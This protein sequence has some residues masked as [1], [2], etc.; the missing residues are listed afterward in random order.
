MDGRVD[1]HE[2]LAP[3]YRDAPG[4]AQIVY[5]QLPEM[6]L[7]D[8]DDA[9]LEPAQPRNNARVRHLEADGELE[10]AG[11][12]AY[13]GEV[14][15]HG[16]QV[17]EDR[18]NRRRAET[19]FLDLFGK[20]Q[21]EG[22]HVSP[23]SKSGNYAARLFAKRPDREGF[24]KADFERAM[25]AL[26]AQAKIRAETYGDRPSREFQRIAIVQS[27]TEGDPDEHSRE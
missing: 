3:Q 9:R 27:E 8:I 17:V 20:V 14:R 7:K 18:I 4:I 11:T 23:N 12:A 19:V 24:T 15:E 26:F 13:A 22:R 6:D 25:E 10:K 16:R 1:A 2:Q 21:Q 5:S